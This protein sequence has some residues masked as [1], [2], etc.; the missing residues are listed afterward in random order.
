MILVAVGLLAYADGRVL[1]QQRSSEKMN[2]GG[3]WE[4]PGGKVEPGETMRE[5]LAREWMEELALPITVGD[6][7]DERVISFP[8]CGPVLLP[9]FEVNF[10]DGHTWWPQEGQRVEVLDYDHVL[11]L[12]CVPSMGRYEAAVRDYLARLRSSHL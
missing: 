6:L 11:S 10:A 7:L 8:E 5:A 9:L 1:V 4:F 3:R 12:P 2:L